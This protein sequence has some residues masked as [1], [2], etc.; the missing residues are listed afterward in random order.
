[1]GDEHTDSYYFCPACQVYSVLKC[2][3]NFTGDETASVEGPI[4]QGD[5]EKL[6]AIIRGCSAPWD[7][8]CRCAAHRAYFRGTL[9]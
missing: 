7:K 5:G 4:T 6:V 1:M 3:D 9:D 2:W 8:K